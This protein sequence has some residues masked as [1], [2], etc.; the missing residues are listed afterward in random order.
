[1]SVSV[2]KNDRHL[3]L[4]VGNGKGRWGCSYEIK[5]RDGWENVSTA[6]DGPERL[7]T[8]KCGWDRML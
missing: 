1:M 3:S 7:R 8:Y 4:E 5:R 2:P 6:F